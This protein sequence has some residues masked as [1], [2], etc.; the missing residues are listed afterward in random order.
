MQIINDDQLHQQGSWAE[1][2]WFYLPDTRAS[3]SPQSKMVVTA[4]KL[5]VATKLHVLIMLLHWLQVAG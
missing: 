2:V 3:L 4:M 1:I 5:H